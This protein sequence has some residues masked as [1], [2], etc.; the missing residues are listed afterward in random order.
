MVA[1]SVR[2]RRR[3]RPA[4]SA[5]WSELVA[6]PRSA[7]AR[8]DSRSTKRTAL[9]EP[10]LRF[11][12]TPAFSEA[13][14]PAWP[15][16]VLAVVAHEPRRLLADQLP[17][18]LA[19][20][21]YGVSG[22]AAPAGDQII[23]GNVRCGIHFAPFVAWNASHRDCGESAPECSAGSAHAGVARQQQSRSRPGAA[24]KSYAPAPRWMRVPSRLLWLSYGLVRASPT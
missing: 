19:Q 22:S 1:T 24:S 21:F 11:T 2:R 14:P 23:A 4:A 17:A 12:A 10:W 13:A 18:H 8:R 5:R 16:S 20:Q 3:R 7:G 15:M 6:H 9:S